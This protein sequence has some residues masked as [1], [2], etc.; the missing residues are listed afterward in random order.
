[1]NIYIYKKNAFN[2]YSKIS[3]KYAIFESIQL[4]DAKNGNNNFDASKVLK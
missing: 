4:F 1:M 3:K 2:F